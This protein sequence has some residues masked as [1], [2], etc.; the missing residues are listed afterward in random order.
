MLSESI[1]KALNKQV[2]M[3]AYASNYYLSIASWC[4]QNGFDG[5]A[6]FFYGQADEERE[7]MMKIFRYINENEGRA[8]APEIGKPQ[9]DFPSFKSLFEI[10]LGH[11][12]KVTAAIHDIMKIA[13]EENDFRTTNLLQWFVDEQLEEETQMQT[14]ID[15]LALI[16]DN[17]LGLYM[18]D[19][20]L[21]DKAAAAEGEAGE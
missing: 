15:K 11:E 8:I 6:Q 9:Q 7:H 2:A 1:A 12:K 21:S 10:A 13:R 4:D 20:E 5:S 16:G 18:I 17:G 14:I 3:E 19:R